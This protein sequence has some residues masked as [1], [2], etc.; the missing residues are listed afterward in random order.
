[1]IYVLTL[2]IAA[3]RFLPHPPNFA[4]LGALGL[5][6]GCYLAGRKS[7]LIPAGALLVSDIIGHLFAVPGM[8]FYNP[9][10]MLATYLGVTLS[11]PI[12]RL[13]RSG[14]MWLKLPA[15][16]LAASTVFFVISNFGVWL[17]PWYPS[18]LSGLAACFTSAIPFYGYTIAGDFLF[19]VI[20]FGAMELSRFH[21][22][23]GR[24]VDPI[25]ASSVA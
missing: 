20:M 16:A 6:A 5:F 8:G 15:G 17:G 2:L 18:T 12:G 22:R 23:D 25:A 14:R 11:V 10:V 3:S 9:V 21:V 13:L 19:A 24:P 7:Y 1:M 4:C